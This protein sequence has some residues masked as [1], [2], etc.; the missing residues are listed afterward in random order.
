MPGRG[1]YPCVR[2]RFPALQAPGPNQDV[3]T[4]GSGDPAGTGCEG[5]GELRSRPWRT[6]DGAPDQGPGTGRAQDAARGVHGW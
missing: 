4:A 5:W 1:C 6:G 3:N 2:A